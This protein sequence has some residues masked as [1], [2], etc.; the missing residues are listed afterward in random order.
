MKV[1]CQNCGEWVDES[2]LCNGL[3]VD[4]FEYPPEEEDKSES[5]SEE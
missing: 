1:K 3:C 4:C 2:D 5:E